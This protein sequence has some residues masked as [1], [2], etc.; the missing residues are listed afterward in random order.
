MFRIWPLCTIWQLSDL[1]W[2]ADFFF[3]TASICRTANSEI[4]PFTIA[5]WP[6][7]VFTIPSI[8]QH[9]SVSFSYVKSTAA[10]LPSFVSSS[11][12]AERWRSSL[13]SSA[14]MKKKTTFRSRVQR[15]HW[16]KSRNNRSAVDV[17]EQTPGPA[18]AGRMRK[19]TPEPCVA[20]TPN[21]KPK[22]NERKASLSRSQGGN[23]WYRSKT[24]IIFIIAQELDSFPPY[25]KTPPQIS[26]C[27]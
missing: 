18:A 14:M 11:S 17:T 20:F 2:N 6:F 21:T 12:Y 13:R 25:A 1:L 19:R 9:L 4:S 8:K 5:H 26:Q 23:S 24:L 16:A 7:G 27:I 22:V 10:R 15:S 3:Q